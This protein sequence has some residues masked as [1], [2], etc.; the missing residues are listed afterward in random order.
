MPVDRSELRAVIWQQLSPHGTIPVGGDSSQQI[1]DAV[2][3][4]IDSGQHPETD[5]PTQGRIL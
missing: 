5:E 2:A 3:D 4:W 1:T